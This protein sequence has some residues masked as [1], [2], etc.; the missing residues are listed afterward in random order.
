M[1]RML[2]AVSPPTRADLLGLGGYQPGE[3]GAGAVKLSGNE[4]GFP[5]LPGVAEAAR[6]AAAEFTAS[7]TLLSGGGRAGHGPG[8]A[9]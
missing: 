8:G 9:G 5:P 3:A 6:A 7:S 1:R 2:R 4:S